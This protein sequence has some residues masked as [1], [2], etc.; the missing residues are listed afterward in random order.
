MTQRMTHKMTL[1]F[2]EPRN[3]KLEQLAERAGI[4]K[5]AIVRQ[6]IDRAAWHLLAGVP[7]CADGKRCLVP[8]MHGP[9]G[10]GQ[11][12]Y[13]SPTQFEM[14]VTNGPGLHQPADPDKIR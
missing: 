7:T 12:S 9:T 4:S 11:L 8:H 3:R 6:L 10:Q 5:A 14:D 1:I 13:P 2:D